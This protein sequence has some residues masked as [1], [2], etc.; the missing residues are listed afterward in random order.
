[1]TDDEFEF[2][3]PEVAPVPEGTAQADPELRRDALPLPFV[4]RSREVGIKRSDIEAFWREKVVGLTETISD[5][6]AD[7]DVKGFR[8]DEI[9][10]SLG[11]G[12]KGGVLFVAEGSIEATI[13]VKLRRS[14]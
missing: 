11:V 8:V 7:H 1:V 13:S 10:F 12:A 14:G 2:L 6:N 3:V 5:A 9:S 4:R